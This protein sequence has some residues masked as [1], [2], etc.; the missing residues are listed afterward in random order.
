VVGPAHL[1]TFVVAATALIVVPGPSVLFVVSRGVT[2]GRRAALLTVAGNA[3]GEYLQVVAV[4]FGVGA[5][6]QRSA[7]VFALVKLVGAAYLIV[8]GV[9]AV[10]RRRM[11]GAAL[12][13]TAVPKGTRRVLREGF[14]VGLTN[15]K[16]IAFFA[17]V[18]PQFA[19]ASRGNVPAQLLVLGVVWVAIALVSDGTWAMAAG[20][21]RAWFARSPRRLARVGAAGG[22]VTIGL[23]LRLAMVRRTD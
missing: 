22:L 8:L 5:I 14:V 4:A 3:A 10:R 13:T 17:A 1:W 7:T 11:L 21:A 18:L 23:G 15:P 2:I 9:R 6:V 16:T 12:A 20:T 19:D